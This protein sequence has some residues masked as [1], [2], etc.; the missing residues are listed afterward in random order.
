MGIDV[1]GTKQKKVVI[2][3]SS[4]NEKEIV[5][6]VLKTYKNVS[7]ILKKVSERK[8]K[9]RIAEY[10]LIYGKDSEVVHKEH[11]YLLK[12]DPT[13]VYF[14]PREA[15]ERHRLATKAKNGERILVMFSGI[16]PIAIAIAKEKD[17]KVVCI[18]INK[19]AHEY[20]E[21]NV[22]INKLGHKILLINADVR[23]VLEKQKEKF[24]RI[25]MPM[26]FD[27]IIMPLPQ[28]AH[29]FL[30]LAIK[31]LKRNGIIHFYFI[32][33]EPLEKA[34]KEAFELVKKAAEKNNRQAELLEAKKVLPY[35]PRKW[36]IV[37]DV[38]I[39]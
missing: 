9:E 7:A 31:N 25:I 38:K 14:S 3:D 12:L 18:E 19:K 35:A 13:K 22:R 29:L 21:E 6:W 1:L 23:D 36:K 5:E 17:V 33:S 26:P 8:G 34:F 11:G 2:V 37:L 4:K 32:G 16:A 27:R 39:I 28:Q 15:T 30:D 24:E 20:A 10:K